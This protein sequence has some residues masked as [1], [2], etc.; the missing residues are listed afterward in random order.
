LRGFQQKVAIVTGGGQ[1]LGAPSPFGSRK[2]LQ[3]RDFDINPDAGH[4]NGELA[5]K[6]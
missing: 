4:E 5:P 6:S 1:A 2:R 3:G